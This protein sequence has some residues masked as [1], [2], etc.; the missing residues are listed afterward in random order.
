[1]VSPVEKQGASI[2]DGNL[3]QNS[4]SAVE[5]EVEREEGLPVAPDGEAVDFSSA[6]EFA[7]PMDWAFE[8]PAAKNSYAAR[9]SAAG[10]ST[11]SLD[12]PPS[13]VEVPGGAGF[14]ATSA[15]I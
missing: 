3:Y 11:M 10:W 7:N 13:L 14:A 8:F 4:Q 1:M 15:L 5:G 12:A 9:R 2:N 6:G